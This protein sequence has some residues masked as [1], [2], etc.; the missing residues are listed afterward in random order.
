MEEEVKSKVSLEPA[1]SMPSIEFAP[2]KW[3]KRFWNGYDEEPVEER[4]PRNG[5]KVKHVESE[6]PKQELAAQTNE[7]LVAIVDGDSHPFIGQPK[8]DRR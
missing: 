4:N 1:F 2:R 5:N 7:D 3:L 6:Q 8:E